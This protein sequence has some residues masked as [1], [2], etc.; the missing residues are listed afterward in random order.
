MATLLS[1]IAGALCIAT[2]STHLLEYTTTLNLYQI[3][4]I[5]ISIKSWG[6]ILMNVNDIL[7][8]SESHEVIELNIK[9]AVCSRAKQ[10][11]SN[12]L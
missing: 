2:E 9:I 11:P 1:I 6:S 12:A 10:T 8:N 4:N 5:P 7:D 3:E